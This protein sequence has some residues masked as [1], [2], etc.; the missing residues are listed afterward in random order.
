M[1][2]TRKIKPVLVL[3]PIGIVENKHFY[4]DDLPPGY[5]NY[6]YNGAIYAIN[7]S[8]KIKLLTYEQFKD[9]KKVLNKASHGN[10]FFSWITLI[11]GII[12]TIASI[13][14]IVGIF[15]K[16]EIIVYIAAA[17]SVLDILVKLITG[18]LKS[19]MSF[20]IITAFVAAFGG[21]SFYS[22][23]VGIC[24]ENF[25][26]SIPVYINIIIHTVGRI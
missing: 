7:I 21:F 2:N 14:G 5:E 22:V 6:I 8:G 23:C 15:A 26:M 25:L 10:S 11:I 4:E 9:T 16:I 17:C 18:E 1:Q 3:D 13:A 19:L 12:S 24:I 20:L